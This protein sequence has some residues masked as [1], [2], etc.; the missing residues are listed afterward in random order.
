[1]RPTNTI[2]NMI[3]YAQNSSYICPPTEA[4]QKAGVVPLDTLP[5]DWWNRI[6]MDLTANFNCAA[7][8]VESVYQEILS[9][10]Q[11]ANITA[12]ATCT[13]QLLAAIRIIA[14]Q[15]A[16]EGTAGAVVG[17]T[18]SGKVYVGADGTMCPNGMGI[19]SQL[20]TTNKSL[21]A[22][23]NEVYSTLTSC[24]ASY[25]SQ[26][27]GKAP[28]NHAASNTDYGVGD[29][30][31]YGHVKLSSACTGTCGVSDGVAAT[32]AAVKAAYDLA[33]CACDIAQTGTTIDVYCKTT[34]KCSINGNTALCLGSLAFCSSTLGAAASCAVKTLTAKGH[35]DYNSSCAACQNLLVTAGFMSYWNGAYNSSNASNLTYFC[36][37]TFGS[38]AACAAT[39]FAP[40][41]HASST[42]DYGVGTTANYG[43]LKVCDTYTSSSSAAAA[44]GVAASQCAAYQAYQQGRCLG[45]VLNYSAFQCAA[46]AEA[47]AAS[48]TVTLGLARSFR[49]CACPTNVCSYDRRTYTKMG[50]CQNQNSCSGFTYI[51]TCVWQCCYSGTAGVTT[52][53]NRRF[54]FHS[55]GYFYSPAG[56]V[57]TTVCATNIT[58]R[59]TGA[60]KVSNI[61]FSTSCTNASCTA[62]NYASCICGA[63]GYYYGN[64]CGNLCGN[65]C[66]AWGCT[67][68]EACTAIRSGMGTGTVTI[69]NKAAANSDTPIALCTGATAVGRSTS[70]ALT[71]NTCLGVL[72]VPNVT[73]SGE[74]SAAL[75]GSTS[76]IVAAANVIAGGGV[77]GTFVSGSDMVVGGCV[78]IGCSYCFAE[79]SG[80][81]GAV[82]ASRVGDTIHVC[83]NKCASQR[84][85][86]KAICC[87]WGGTFGASSL[88]GSGRICGTCGN[89]YCWT[90]LMGYNVQACYCSGCF[91]IKAGCVCAYICGSCSSTIFSNRGEFAC[92]SR[93]I[94]IPST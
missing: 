47:A 78:I 25:D 16:S 44:N 10:L 33:C 72:C 63:N 58:H 48:C 30:S 68:A 56:L 76:N 94:I 29:A 9:V 77:T 7:T 70:C 86:Y 41:S 1:M 89:Y 43:H 90:D 50:T 12:D 6:L 93:F 75:L 34:C 65:A 32:P 5:A 83:L 14:R 60:S 35:S 52:C 62:T 59:D 46:T 57:G 79:T 23:V 20:N 91:V 22:A 21:V 3:V 39:A 18:D 24:I 53:T 92:N 37:G 19:P 45:N 17:S 51:D 81:T 38:A 26:F 13:N 64:I 55:N 71:F 54:C 2:Q 11:D 74:V 28:T 36:G 85:I 88:I 84:C 4:Q 87:A 66:K 73:A 49:W 31:N 42:T 69:S 82:I 40:K 80:Y 67:F 27:T 61:V 15:Y 8:S